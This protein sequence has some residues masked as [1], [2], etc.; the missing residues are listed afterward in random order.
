MEGLLKYLWQ[1]FTR[2]F[3]HYDCNSFMNIL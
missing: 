1:Q 2:L 3:S